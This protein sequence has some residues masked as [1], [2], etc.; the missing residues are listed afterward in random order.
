[1]HVY[2]LIKWI[3]WM[4]FSILIAFVFV[5]AWIRMLCSAYHNKQ[6]SII[7][8]NFIFCGYSNKETIWV[9]GLGSTLEFII[10]KIFQSSRSCWILQFRRLFQPFCLRYTCSQL[11]PTLIREKKS[12]IW[13]I[14]KTMPTIFLTHIYSILCIDITTYKYTICFPLA[15]VT[16]RK[17]NDSI[18]ENVGVCYV[19]ISSKF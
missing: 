16:S 17:I 7:S 9:K 11:K 4:S 10:G 19:D 5:C 2:Q 18:M 12:F 8:L 15:H 6:V 1:M 3:F 13:R 14:S